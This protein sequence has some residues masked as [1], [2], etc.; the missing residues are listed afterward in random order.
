MIH[1]HM[2]AVIH[3]QRIVNLSTEKWVREK[4]YK[5]AYPFGKPNVI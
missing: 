5:L 1:T 2:H 4:L 3:K